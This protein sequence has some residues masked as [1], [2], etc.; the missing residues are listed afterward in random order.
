MDLPTDEVTS[1]T[2]SAGRLLKAYNIQPVELTLEVT[3]GSYT[4]VHKIHVVR[5]TY[6]G[7]LQ[8]TDDEG[9]EVAY[10]PTFKKTVYEYSVHVPS[11]RKYL[12]MQLKG[13]EKTSTGLTVN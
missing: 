5:G 6:L 13:A 2:S 8:I 7:S 4:E 1:L 9:G 10:T 3:E 12:Q 11:S